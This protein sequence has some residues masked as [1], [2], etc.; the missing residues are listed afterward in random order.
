MMAS[1]A[2]SQRRDGARSS[3]L[4]HLMAFDGGLRSQRARAAHH[5]PRR[6]TPSKTEHVEKNRKNKMRPRSGPLKKSVSLTKS[7]ETI[8]APNYFDRVPLCFLGDPRPSSNVGWSVVIL[9][10]VTNF[11]IDTRQLF[12][13]FPTTEI[14]E[15][16]R[17]IS[18]KAGS[19][20]RI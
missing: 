9:F 15:Q 18:W 2:Y 4:V 8:V 14:Q 10:V 20:L 5:R 12:M 17:S 7:K 6:E 3:A 16:G 13:T 1:T 19:D 11:R